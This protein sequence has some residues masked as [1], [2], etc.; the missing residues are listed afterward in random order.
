LEDGDILHRTRAHDLLVEEYEREMDELRHELKAAVGRISFTCDLWSSVILR[1]F[2]AI[3][4]H[5]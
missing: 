4:L 2:F 1:S 5:Y 3:T